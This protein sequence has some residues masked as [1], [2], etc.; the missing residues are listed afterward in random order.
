MSAKEK[1]VRPC[2]IVT[3]EAIRKMI[4]TVPGPSATLKQ[5]DDDLKK[6]IK[7]LNDEGEGDS[8]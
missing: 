3:L 5:L 8:C 1:A 2:V 7:K 6:W 4:K